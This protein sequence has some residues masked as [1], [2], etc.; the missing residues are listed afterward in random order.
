[1]IFIF[2]VLFVIYFFTSAIPRLPSTE[3]TLAQ[4][5]DK[6][7]VSVKCSVSNCKYYSHLEC[8]AEAIEINC[9]DSSMLASDSMETCCDTFTP[10][11]G[12]EEIPKP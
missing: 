1:M 7:E 11:E 5:G 8:T 12:R 9:D 4:G 10:V 6:M 3:P 2:I